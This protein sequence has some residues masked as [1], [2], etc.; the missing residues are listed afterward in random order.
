M[1]LEVLYSSLTQFY[2]IHTI[3]KCLIFLFSILHSAQDTI[4]EPDENLCTPV[5]S[6]SKGDLEPS[7]SFLELNW[8]IF[9][10]YISCTIYYLA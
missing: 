1:L 3:S 7:R 10:I 8:I 6:K 4:D 9:D 5:R 2:L